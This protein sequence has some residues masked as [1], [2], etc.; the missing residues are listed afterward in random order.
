MSVLLLYKFNQFL[1]VAKRDCVDE[2]ESVNVSFL[3][4]VP[5]VIE[6]C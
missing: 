3:M 6:L 4:S 2:V 1:Q 5:S